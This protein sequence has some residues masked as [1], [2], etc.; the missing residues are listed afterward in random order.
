M[1]YGIVSAG[2]PREE[3]AHGLNS[4]V[5]YAIHRKKT[6]VNDFLSVLPFLSD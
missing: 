1:D 2:Y 3:I 5:T 4:P 6:N